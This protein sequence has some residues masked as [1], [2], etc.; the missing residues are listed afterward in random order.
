MFSSTATFLLT[1]EVWS[2]QAGLVAA[3]FMAIIPGYTQRSVAGSFDNEG[4]AI[5]ALQISFYAWLKAAKSGS[6]MWSVVTAFLYWYMS[7]AWGGYVF[8]I[9][10]IALHVF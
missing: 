9:N 8:I 7:S 4:V 5:F 10:M 3:V 2:T 6:V 1:Q